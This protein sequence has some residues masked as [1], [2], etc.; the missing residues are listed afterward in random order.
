MFEFSTMNIVFSAQTP[1]LK[2]QEM[3]ESKLVKRS[4]NKMIPDGK[5]MIIFIDDLNMPRRD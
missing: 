1:S 2:T 5:K 3:I 4:K